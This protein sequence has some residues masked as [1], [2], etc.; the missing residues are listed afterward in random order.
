MD[1]HGIFDGYGVYE[2][3]GADCPPGQMDVLGVCVPTLGTTGT[4]CPPGTVEPWPGAAQ[5]GYCVGAGGVSST[6]KA[7]PPGTLEPWPGAGICITSMSAPSGPASQPCPPG[8]IGWPQAGIPC[9][10]IPGQPQAAPPI[11]APQC[12]PG[13]I[14]WPQLG[15]PCQVVNVPGAPPTPAGLPA[16]QVGAQC[17]PGQIGWPQLGIPCTPI[18]QAPSGQ[19]PPPVTVTPAAPPP[20]KRPAPG[21]VCGPLTFGCKV[22]SW[23]VP[24]ALGVGALVVLGVMMKKPKRAT[25]NRRRR[26]R[27][28]A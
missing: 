28:A 27:K 3:L 25:P 7:C 20:A 15:I 4:T 21:K 26:H 9:T 12:P 5:M 23:A 8:Q 17:P 24:A 11:S 6:Q 19:T 18:P 13:Q 1:S 22:P 16:P 10:P 2:Q 14:G